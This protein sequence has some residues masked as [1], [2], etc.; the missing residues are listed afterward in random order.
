[1]S[2]MNLDYATL[3]TQISQADHEAVPSYNKRR[4]VDHHLDADLGPCPY[5]GDIEAAPIVLLLANPCS[6]DVGPNGHDPDPSIRAK[7]PLWGLNPGGNEV[8]HRWWLRRLGALI[9]LTDLTTVSRQVVATQ[10][11][12]WASRKFDPDCTLPSRRLM[13]QVAESAVD[14]GALLVVMRSARLWNES[15][16]IAGYGNK[17]LARN[18]R[19]SYV[20]RGNFQPQ[21]W[22][23]IETAITHC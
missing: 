7:W 20:S 23:K 17:V 4:H 13:L 5:E 14:R 21:D 16:K 22:R 15:P 3:R 12:P 19:C 8:L 11:T 9:A 2:H 18:P 10:L 1:M 6:N